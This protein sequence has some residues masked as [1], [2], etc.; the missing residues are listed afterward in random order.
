LPQWPC[1]VGGVRVVRRDGV[2]GGRLV[3]QAAVA[4]VNW[5]I[6]DGPSLQVLL[7]I[8]AAVTGSSP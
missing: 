6:A 1:W 2:V 8:L 3:D 7:P 5:V 4:T